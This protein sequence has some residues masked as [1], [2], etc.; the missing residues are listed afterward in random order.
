MNKY[1]ADHEI[2]V[3]GRRGHEIKSKMT[4]IAKTANADLLK[5]HRVNQTKELKANQ[6]SILE[7]IEEMG[8]KDEQLA[9]IL[10][11]LIR[12]SK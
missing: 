8:L 5:T 3:I 6:D 2:N 7:E 12:K 11:G 1:E 4:N 9:S 10:E